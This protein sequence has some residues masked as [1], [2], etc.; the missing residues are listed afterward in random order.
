M[1]SKK[2]ISGLNK[3]LKLDMIIAVDQ[4]GGTVQRLYD[5]SDKK[6]TFIPNMHDV[7]V[8]NN[9]DI[10]YKI[11]NIIGSETGSIGCNAVFGP[12]LDIGDY[13]ISAM[14]KRLISDDKDIVISNGMEIFKGIE[15]TGLISIV[16]HFPG[17][18]STA[19]D[20]HN[21]EISIVNKLMMN[22]IILICNLLLLLLIIM[23]L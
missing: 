2:F 9:K 15:D 23:F 12:V 3:Y 21:N 10:S 13:N 4:E 1:K 16:K 6:A 11:G 18:G 22:Y 17:I 7:G 5:I 14:G 20:T 8:L 19:D